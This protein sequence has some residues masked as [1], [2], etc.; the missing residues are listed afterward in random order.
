MSTPNSKPSDFFLYIPK[1]EGDG[2][3]WSIYKSRFSYAVD[4]AGMSDHLSDTHLAPTAQTTASPFTA[5]EATSLEAHE[6][7]LKIWKFGQAIVK[8]AIASTIPDAL[9]LRV[10]GA[11]SAAGLWKKASEE[12]EK[13]SKMVT[14]DL[15]RRL[16]DERCT[17][18]TE[19]Q[20]A[21]RAAT[22]RHPSSYCTPSYLIYT[23]DTTLFHVSPAC[24]FP[25]AFIDAH[26]VPLH[27]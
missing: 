1:C 8:Q 23:S 18:L 6:K 5:T 7:E 14:V 12:F 3:N 9:F 26:R 13:K 15:R 2:T 24:L 27:P 25:C 4:A 22:L 19:K 21:W 11:T 20:F 17:D 10:K 16:Q